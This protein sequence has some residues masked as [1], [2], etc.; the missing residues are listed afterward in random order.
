MYVVQR[1][2][3]WSLMILTTVIE[4]RY[5][6]LFQPL[7]LSTNWKSKIPENLGP[8]VQVPMMHFLYLCD[9]HLFY[10]PFR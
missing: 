5:P 9:V 6:V 3:S 7:I 10:A 2:G 8:R 1:Q 4:V